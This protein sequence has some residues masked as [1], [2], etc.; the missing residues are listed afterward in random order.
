MG[1]TTNRKEVI[2]KKIVD[3][4]KR[5]LLYTAI[6][7]LFFSAF[8]IY[9]RLILDEYGINIAHY[10]YLL[11][12]SM[13]LAKVIVL[14]QMFK[15]GERYFGRP[16]IIPT[17]YKTIIFSIF[18]IIFS[19]AEHFVMGYFEGKSTE[20]LYQSLTNKRLS[21][22]LAA[23]LPMSFFFFFFFA[24]LEIGE[25]LPNTTLLELFFK[26]EKKEKG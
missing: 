13:I 16:L 18:V 24:F 11:F 25:F 12:Q 9:R 26:K 20:I 15:L 14:G 7:T 21:E 17:M 1:N 8:S 4:T 22:I 19:V 3:E 6:L 10:G 23:I 5:F 2:K